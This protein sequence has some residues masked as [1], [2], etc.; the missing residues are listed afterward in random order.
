MRIVL[1]NVLNANL[2]IDG[3]EVAKINRGFVLLV[4]FTSGDDESLVLAMLKKVLSLRTFQ[5]ENGHTNLA[6]EDI[7][8][9]ILSVSQFTLYGDVKKGRRPSFISAMEPHRANELYEFWFNELKKLHPASQSGVFGADMKVN[10]TNDGPF[11]LILDSKEVVG[12]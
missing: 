1:Q 12:R 3:K 6:L 10:L 2:T 9:E 7:N 8:G 4:G 5:D 11:T